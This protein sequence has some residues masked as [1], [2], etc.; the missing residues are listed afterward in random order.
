M[1][2]SD[3]IMAASTTAMSAALISLPIIAFLL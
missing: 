1:S 2:G 3:W